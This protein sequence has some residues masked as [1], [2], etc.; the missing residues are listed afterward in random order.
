MTFSTADLRH[1]TT[2]REHDK[3]LRVSD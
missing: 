1:S 2:L 3:E